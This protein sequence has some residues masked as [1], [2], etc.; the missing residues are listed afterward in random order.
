MDLRSRALA[1]VDEGMSCRAAARRYGVAAATVIGWHD[2]RRSTGGYAAKA[3]GG[4]TR[5]QRIEAHHDTILALHA[6]RRDITLDELR[7]EL[8]QAGVT[9]A[10]STLHRFFARHGITRKKRSGTRSSKT[11]PTS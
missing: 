1:A 11:V 3:Q 7:R 9:V 6:A 10:I 5:S 8:G 2:Q 4:D